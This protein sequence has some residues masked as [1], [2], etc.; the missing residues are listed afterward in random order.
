MRGNRLALSPAGLGFVGSIPACAGEPFTLPMNRGLCAI[1]GSIPACA[2]EPS[3]SGLPRRH[4]R[5]YP[6]VC[7]GTGRMNGATITDVG[8][9]PRVRGNPLPMAAQH[10]DSGSIPA[11]AGEPK[12]R[13]RDASG[14]RVYPRVCGGTLDLPFNHTSPPG[15]S[16]RVRGNLHRLDR[17]RAVIGSIPACAGEPVGIVVDRTSQGLSPRVRGNRRGQRLPSGASGSIP[18]CAGEPLTRFNRPGLSPRVRGNP[19][20]TNRLLRRVYPRVCGGTPSS[21]NALA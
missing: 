10:V 3:L 16:P 17:E 18:A 5:V 15:L 21:T 19:S 13:R 6:R 2:G 20:V 11:C 12:C 14:C 1:V 7:G 9:S 8:L 4:Q